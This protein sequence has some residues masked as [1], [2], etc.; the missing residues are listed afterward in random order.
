MIEFAVILALL[1]LF[2]W[3][4]QLLGRQ[5]SRLDRLE[6]QRKW[7]EVN[8]LLSKDNNGYKMAVIEADK[9]LDKALKNSGFAG[10]T[11]GERLKS[12]G[13]K[14]GN[15]NAVWDAHRL[16]N[17][18]VHEEVKLSKQQAIRASAAFKKSLKNLGAL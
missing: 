11:M 18:I 10:D 14:L 1:L 2:L 3:L 16:R 5:P 4:V 17:R 13:K 12:A 8:S 6:F 9:L 15:Q 7:Q